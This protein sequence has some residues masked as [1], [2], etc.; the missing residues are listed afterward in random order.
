ML[1]EPAD[2]FFFGR[3][4]EI[5]FL[6]DVQYDFFRHFHTYIFCRD[7]FF[8]NIS[9]VQSQILFVSHHSN[10][11]FIFYLLWSDYWSIFLKSLLVCPSLTFCTFISPLRHSRNAFFPDF[12]KADKKNAIKRPFFLFGGQ[13]FLMACL[14]HVSGTFL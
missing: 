14:T 13:S 1:I 11:A 4:R 8:E 12:Q 7:S 10:S 9:P 5:P 3:K 2:N 6:D